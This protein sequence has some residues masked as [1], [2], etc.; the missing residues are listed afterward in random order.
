[1]LI[2]GWKLVVF[3]DYDFFGQVKP[4]TSVYEL[5][6]INIDPYETTNLVEVNPGRVAQMLRAIDRWEE[7]IGETQPLKR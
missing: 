2:E 1:M 3:E 4:G 6:K 5:F 7:N